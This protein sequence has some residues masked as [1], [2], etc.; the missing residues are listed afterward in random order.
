MGC[1]LLRGL[2]GG[3]AN[4]VMRGVVVEGDEERDEEGKRVFMLR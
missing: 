1:H 4:G 2:G 3:H